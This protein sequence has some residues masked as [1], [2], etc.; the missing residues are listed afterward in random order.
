MS[1]LS[2]FNEC[3]VMLV[4]ADDDRGYIYKDKKYAQIL[5]SVN[6]K[7]MEKGL[8][9]VT[10]QNPLSSF[11]KRDMYG[12][13]IT[14][15]GILSRRLILN[16]IASL[17]TFGRINNKNPWRKVWEKIIIKLNPKVIISIQPWKDLC[18]VAKNYNIWIADI[19]HGIFSNESDYGDYYGYEYRK[20]EEQ[21]G[22]P[23]CILC[24]NQRSKEWVEK[25]CP[26]TVE[27]KVI[28]HP[29]LNRFINKNPNDQLVNEALINFKEKN[30]NK[31]IVLI[32]A[33]SIKESDIG[34][35]RLG[36][37]DSIHELIN[38]CD[39]KVEFWLRLHPVSL[40]I[41][42]HVEIERIF[43]DTFKNA[44]NVKWKEPTFCALPLILSMV[45]LHITDHSSVTIEA[46]FFGVRT[47]LLH[48]NREVL[49]TWYYDEIS[50]GLAECI[51]NKPIDLE[52]WITRNMSY[53]KS[54]NQ[55]KSYKYEESLNTFISDICVKVSNA[56]ISDSNFN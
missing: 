37:L 23:D 8:T 24:W 48:E 6:E 45:K 29:F 39:Q 19:Q 15:N 4:C 16:K 30:I 54:K 1:E 50:T 20:V 17:L 28:G 49:H 14:V 7:L 44:S 12:N 11:D 31:K 35:N 52:R 42:S 2:D 25:N 38:N 53:E 27:A 55:Y 32:T 5:D 33:N 56:D 21:K 40:K 18:I 9:T 41:L 46:S 22:W 36:F 51:S 10:V 34:F 26:V 43:T 47:A 3:D 13:V